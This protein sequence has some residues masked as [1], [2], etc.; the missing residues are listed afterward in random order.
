[1]G[2]PGFENAKIGDNR[3]IG[4]ESVPEP[5]LLACDIPAYPPNGGSSG[6]CFGGGSLRIDV[7]ITAYKS[8]GQETHA[9]AE[10]QY[11][12]LGAGPRFGATEHI[13]DDST[14][15]RNNGRLAQ[16]AQ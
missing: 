5:G 3:A 8:H 12:D 7:Q 2:L 14:S 13:K 9:Y 1:M 4:I 10:K 6:E 15:K 11:F 16:G